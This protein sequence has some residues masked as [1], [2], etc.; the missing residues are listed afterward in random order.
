MLSIK[1]DHTAALSEVGA[2]E[3]QMQA[4]SGES[5]QRLGV[6][7]APADFART[8]MRL[9]AKSLAPVKRAEIKMFRDKDARL[10]DTVPL[11]LIGVSVLGV[12]CGGSGGGSGSGIPPSGLAYSSDQ[13]LYTVGVAIIPN[14]PSS[15]GGAA[16]SYSVAPALPVGLSFN[17]STGVISGTPTVVTTTATYIVTAANASGYTTA[18]LSIAVDA[19]APS[20]LAYTTNPAIYTKGIAI[21]ANTPNS[22]GGAVV[23][24]SVAPALPLGLNLNTSTGI[25]SG[26]PTAVTATANYIVTSTNSGGN[27]TVSVNITINDVP[28]SNLTYSANPAAYLEGRPIAT[29]S[30]SSDGGTVLTYSVSPALPNGL[31]LNTATG[32]ITGTPTA[33]MGGTAV[34]TISAGNSG[35]STT[36]N[37]TI[38]VTALDVAVGG[39]AH[40]AC[41]AVNGGAQCWGDNAWGELGNNSTTGS[42]VP[43]QVTG[44]TSGV[45]AIATGAFH[46]CALV[47]GGVECWGWNNSG[48]LG[49]NS[50]ANSSV[51]VQVS[52]LTSGVEAIA[53]GYMSTCAI[54]NGGAQCWG[55]NGWGEL[56]NSS[57]TT[58]CSNTGWPCSLVPVQVT[59]LTSGVEVIGAG[60]WSTCAIVN[61][62]AQCW[63]WNGYGEL[64]NN[65]TAVYSPVP[66]QVSGL[67]SGVEAIA[68]GGGQTCAVVNGGVECWG[69]NNS[70]QLGNN[71]TANSS[72]PVQ[73]SGLTSGVEAIAAGYWSTC[74]IVKGGVECWGD[75]SSGELGNGTVT[76]CT[77]GQQC[78]LCTNGQCSLVP[79]QVIGL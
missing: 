69:W 3:P 41:A 42:S 56:G 6:P 77:Y 71:S 15:S 38:T 2:Q 30:P 70:G 35:G 25:I 40:Y 14:S 46:S 76:M 7:G 4:S 47:N 79:V 23:S 9:E 39:Q 57:T 18:G 53:A 64:G 10:M 34:Y 66:V 68:G 43:V 72:V 67:T 58:T 1:H 27:A 48:Q 5:G 13:A 44:L 17:T 33:A 51:P 74:A 45:T 59:S 24:Y 22:S 32:A 29:N 28:P 62:G 65:S 55:D 50:T 49:N 20:R 37:L 73:V 26:V 60:Y 61:G 21:T 8:G 36:A 12:A 16:V 63:G 31:S 11:L 52:G 78:N 75:N 19:P 54:V